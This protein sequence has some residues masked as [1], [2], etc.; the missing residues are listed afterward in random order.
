MD[1]LS[2]AMPI[3]LTAITGGFGFM[4]KKL[5][6]I[7]RRQAAHEASDEATFVGLRRDMTEVKTGMRDGNQKLDRLIEHMLENPTPSPRLR[8]RKG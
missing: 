6:D 3:F 5:L 2:M 4:G 8:K 7:D 1:W